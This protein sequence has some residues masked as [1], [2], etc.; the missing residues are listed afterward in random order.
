MDLWELSRPSLLSLG[1]FVL[2]LLLGWIVLRRHAM[3]RLVWIPYVFASAAACLVLFF[4][5]EADPARRYAIAVALAAGVSGLI[6]LGVSFYLLKDFSQRREAKYP[7]LLRRVALGFSYLVILFLCIKLLNRDFSLTPVLVTSGV[8]SMVLGFALQDILSNFLS[9]VVITI[10]RPFVIDDWIEAGEIVGRV[11]EITW[12]TTKICTRDNDYVIIPNKAIANLELTNHNCPTT[13]HRERIR[14]GLPY[15]TLPSLAKQALCD[16]TRHVE[17]VLETP[18][19]EVFIVDFADS[20]ITY[21]LG[22]WIDS[23]DLEYLLASNV[24][25][26][27]F[28]A[29][30]R[31]GISVPFPI[32][33]LRPSQAEP[34]PSHW[35]E[36][37]RFRLHVVQGPLK[38]LFFPLRADEAV[39]GRAEGCAVDLREPGISKQHA[40]LRRVDDTYLVEDLSSVHGTRVNDCP[41]DGQLLRT[42]DEIQLGSS[43]LRFEEVTLT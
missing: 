15:E 23:P 33:T 9:G 28:Y 27:I 21:E 35:K 12:R 18:G 17:G 14:L 22:F 7:P 2:L 40:R 19:P 1:S 32:R 3:R 29:L 30:K 4:G 43:I 11:V 39:I 24:R 6:Q 34:A 20:S 5:S 16:A 41:A 13:L 42:G 25:L 26:E 38:G 36:D 31:H 37:Y 10:E 8:L